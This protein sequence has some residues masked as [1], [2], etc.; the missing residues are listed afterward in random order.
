MVAACFAACSKNDSEQAEGDT[1]EAAPQILTLISGGASEYE[2]IYPENST[3]QEANFTVSFTELFYEK[4]GV[5]LPKRD[6]FLKEG[7][8]HD[9]DTCKIFIGQTNYSVSQTAYEDLQYQDIKIITSGSNI[10]LAAYTNTGF[11]GILRW[12]ERNVFEGYTEGDLTLQETNI[13]EPQ[14]AGYPISDWTINENP[15]EKYQIVYAD[16]NIGKTVLEFQE[17]LAKK[18]GWFL[19]AG[20]DTQMP[21]SD[22]EIL[23]GDTNREENGKVGKPSALNYVIKVEDNKLIFKYGGIHTREKILGEFV[24]IMIDGADKVNIPSTYRLEGDFYDDPNDSSVA[25]GTDVRIMCANLMANSS[26]YDSGALAKHGFLFERRAEIFHAHIDYY[27]PTVIGFQEACTYW[28]DAINSY[29]NI[30]YWDVLEVP[31]PKFNNTENIYSSVMWRNDLYKLVDSGAELYS[32]TNNTR[33]RWYAWVILEDIKTKKQF[34]VVSTH[35]NGADTDWTMKQVEELTTFVNDT[36]K[37]KGIPVFTMGDFNSNEW[38]K[39]WKQYLPAIDS[40]DC[41][42]ADASK[43]V[44]VVDSWHGWGVADTDVGG[45]CDHI[46]ATKANVDILKFETL[47]YLD[48]I[49]GSDHAWL[50]GDFKF[51]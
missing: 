27:E 21:E 3:P 22:Y 25:D 5:T 20:L 31:N 42:V 6:D 8:S 4:T 51:K 32:E 29:E 12:F 19:K 28:Y 49:W 46:T 14:V 36:A 23:I 16:K 40:Y 1:T 44:N 9:T 24:N 45:S 2:I 47:V 10:V 41:M 18:S 37:N 34:C 50:L 13:H 7:E 11:D 33:C 43:R 38:S 48:Q 17:Q 15:L 39:A 30:E 26:S 35:W